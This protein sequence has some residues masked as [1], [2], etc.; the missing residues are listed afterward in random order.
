MLGP[1]AGDP[2]DERP[3]T[4]VRVERGACGRRQVPDERLVT[5]LE[6]RVDGRE[7][8]RMRE[9]QNTPGDV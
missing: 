1:P 9:T 2:A 3:A 8:N 4:S 7:W 6:P 5:L